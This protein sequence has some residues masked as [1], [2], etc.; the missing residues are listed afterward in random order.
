MSGSSSDPFS[1]DEEIGGGELE[2]V[3]KVPPPPIL[4]VATNTQPKATAQF[5]RKRGR[6]RLDN[7][8]KQVTLRLDADIIA[9]FRTTGRGWQTRINK[10]LREAAGL[11]EPEA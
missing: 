6:P 1:L 7:P 2:T 10:A 11:K 4:P 9:H 5:E 8:K 3:V